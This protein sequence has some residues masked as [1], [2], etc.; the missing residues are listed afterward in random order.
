MFDRPGFRPSYPPRTAPSADNHSD[1]DPLTLPVVL[2]PLTTQKWLPVVIGCGH[3][4]RKAMP[5]PTVHTTLIAVTAM[6][7]LPLVE[8]R[9]AAE[10]GSC[11][12]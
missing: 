12:S 8:T 5:A 6:L 3:P 2:A 1:R 10:S 7:R 4:V 9:L 11:T